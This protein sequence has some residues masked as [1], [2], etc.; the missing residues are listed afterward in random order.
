MDSSILYLFK[1]SFILILLW[2]L[3]SLILFLAI[4]EIVLWY[5]KINEVSSSLDRIANSLEIIA[6]SDE[7]I[8]IEKEPIIINQS[9][10]IRLATV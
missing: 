6:S 1:S 4:R 9:T 3:I 5:F 7:E 8:T 10:A 2:L